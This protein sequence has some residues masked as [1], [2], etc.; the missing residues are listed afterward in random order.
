MPN[1]HHLGRRAFLGVSGAAVLANSLPALAKPVAPADNE[2][3]IDK[4]VVF[5]K[6]DDTTLRADIYRPP[7]GTEKRMALMHLHGGFA[8]GSVGQMT[9]AV[10]A[11]L[12]RTS[13]PEELSN[14]ETATTP[15]GVKA[16][17]ENQGGAVPVPALLSP[18]ILGDR[19]TFIL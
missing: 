6:G 10:Y 18:S 17:H 14:S 15:A 2:V 13:S 3:K 16:A 9:M 7:S 19:T 1:N 11:R 12:L 8:R 4:D 5:G